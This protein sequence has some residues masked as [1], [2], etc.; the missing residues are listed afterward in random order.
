MNSIK[1]LMLIGLFVLGLSNISNAFTF[2]GY[3]F[4]SEPLF[5]VS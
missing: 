1:K 5:S 2:N 3:R 4:V